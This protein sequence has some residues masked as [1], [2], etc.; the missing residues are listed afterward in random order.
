MTPR[1][2]VVL[3]LF[4]AASAASAQPCPV[5]PVRQYETGG[6]S[7]F[8]ALGDLNGDGYADVVATSTSTAVGVMLGSPGGLGDPTLVPATSY[9]SAIEIA[10]LDGDGMLDLAVS[11]WPDQVAVLIGDG[12]GQPRAPERTV[13]RQRVLVADPGVPGGAAATNALRIHL[14]L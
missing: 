14:G 11:G 7:N 5:L 6:G 10:D 13:V 9:P 4:A 1:A 12:A 8:A 2:L 3:A